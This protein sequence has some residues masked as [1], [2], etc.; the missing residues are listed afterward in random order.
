MGPIKFD[1]LTKEQQE[2]LL[3]IRLFTCKLQEFSQRVNNKLFVYLFGRKLGDW[4]YHE[5]LLGK[6]GKNILAFFNTLN[7]YEKGV[8]ISNIFFNEKLYENC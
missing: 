2:K 8:I 3:D 7:E 5:N 4:H 6:N 1:S